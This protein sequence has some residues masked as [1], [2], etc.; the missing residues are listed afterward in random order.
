MAIRPVDLQGAI[1]QA[2]QTAP[3]QRQGEVAPQLAQAAAAQ[4]FAA[5]VEERDETVA[6]TEH[7]RGNRVEE[8]KEPDQYKGRSGTKK[9]E[10]QAGDPFD[11]LEESVLG[12]S[13]PE[14]EHLVDFTA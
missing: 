10:R 6:E 4:Q 7:G 5:Q 2:T 3:V 11:A 13:A 12:T 14:G 9:R 8:K 1:F